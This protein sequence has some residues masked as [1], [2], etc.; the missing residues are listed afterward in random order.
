MSALAKYLISIGKTVFGYDAERSV[1][2][3][4]LENLGV[5]ID[6]GYTAYK[7]VKDCEVVV[8]T[9]A[10]PSNDLRME[11]AR[12]EGKIIISR[13]QLLYEISRLFNTVIAVSGC[14]GKTTCTAMLTH[15]FACAK[16]N[17]TAHIGGRDVKYGNFLTVG[18]DFFISEACEYK[19]NF[20]L[21]KPNISLILNSQP[22]HLE[23]YGSVENLKKA[24]LQFAEC[25]DLSVS[26]YSDLPIGSA[27]T[28][29]FDKRADFY[30][31][32]IKNCGGKYSFSVCEKGKILGEIT[33]NIYGKHNVLNALAALVVARLVNISFAEIRNGLTSFLGVERRFEVIAKHNGAEVICDY[34]HH[35]DEIKASIRIAKKITEGNLYVIFQPHTYSR[36]KRLFKRFVQVLS[37][38]KQLLIYKTFAAREYY[39]DSGSA[40]TL[41]Q[42]IKKSRYA[43]SV[44]EIEYFVKEAIKGD[45]VLILGAGE[46]YDIAKKI[47]KNQ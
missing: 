22:D 6:Y 38:I 42:A 19:K 41:S 27:I 46:I 34:A 10:I 43:D 31:F 8:Y 23:C 28:F 36:T 12:K 1:F 29:G 44:R 47:F 14:H 26:L 32:K 2:C 5:Q 24:Y 25:A 7:Q 30:A 15:I 9:D 21:L 11:E 33:L 16:K 17:F 39:D 4:E 18:N 35:P 3:K 20:L 37:P 45:T 13:G 40:L